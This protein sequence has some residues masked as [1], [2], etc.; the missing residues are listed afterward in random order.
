MSA[1]S[2]RHNSE[3]SRFEVL[4]G[5]NV[6]GQAAYLDRDAEEQRIYYHTVIDEDFGGRGLAGRLAAKA[7]DE[8]VSAGLGIVP[9]CPFIKKYL[10]KHPQYSGS[11]T[12]PTPAILE[13]LSVS[14][15]RARPVR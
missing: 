2:L 8:T 1:I 14:L 3:R 10:E 6:I 15:P 13:F 11:V 4:D 5:E 12:K 7:L 9:V